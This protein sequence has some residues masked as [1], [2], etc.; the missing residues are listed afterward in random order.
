MKA[1][2]GVVAIVTNR[3]DFVCEETRG[4]LRKLEVPFDVVLCKPEGVSDKNPRFESVAAGTAAPGLAPAE[5]VAFVG[6]NIR[7]FPHLDQKVRL[8][9][10]GA[11]GDFGRRFIIIPNPLYGSWE[12]NPYR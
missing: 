4:N 9:G 1:L 2:G 10:E 11:L 5:V 8:E 3:A 6:D 12:A 7:D